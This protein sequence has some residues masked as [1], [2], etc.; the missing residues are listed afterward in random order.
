MLTM[1]LNELYGDTKKIGWERDFSTLTKSQA[2]VADAGVHQAQKV[3]AGLDAEPPTFQI[4]YNKKAEEIM[5][6]KPVR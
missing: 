3:G 5:N 2:K 6:K 1:E 4:P